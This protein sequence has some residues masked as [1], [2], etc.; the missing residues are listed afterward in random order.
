M[1][2]HRLYVGTIGEGLFRSLDAGRTCR[3]ACDGT[4]VECAAHPV[5]SQAISESLPE[6]VVV[7]SLRR[8]DGGLD[9]F[10]LSMAEAYV[11]GVEVD[12]PRT[13]GRV[14]LPTYPFQRESYWLPDAARPRTDGVE[15]IELAHGA[16]VVR[17]AL[18][19]AT[20]PWLADH[21]VRGTIVL[22][23]AAFVDL[24]HRAGAGRIDELT[25]QVPLVLPE[26]G[27]VEVQVVVEPPDD[28][29]R[30]GATG[31]TR[32]VPGR[33]PARYRYRSATRTTGSRT[34]GTGTVPRS[35]G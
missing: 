17:A 28:A 30:R 9:R 20:D 34:P 10:F 1:T 3:R 22:P 5:L 12:W 14:S 11:R 15:A 27:G 2:P 24:V 19:L 23:G 13:G 26:Q 4:F 21:Q 35:G 33:H 31:L 18:S 16:A 6:A 8:G 32:R 29:G 7:G 25:L